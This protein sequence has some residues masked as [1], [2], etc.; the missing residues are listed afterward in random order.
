MSL[1]LVVLALA[2]AGALVAGGCGGTDAATS[3]YVRD[4]NAARAGLEHAI[5]ALPPTDAATSTRADDERTLAGYE[6]AVRDSL[7]RLQRAHPPEKVGAL[8]RRLV[9]AV[10]GYEDALA[11][12]RDRLVR[13]PAAD[14][15][16]IREQLRDAL[17]VTGRRVNAAIAALNGG[18]E[19]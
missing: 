15:L 5:A 2:V 11:R 13:A 19:A 1:R 3:A 17:A 9:T 10:A 8:H 12:A 18:L 16:A 4:V 7:R 6:A 14:V